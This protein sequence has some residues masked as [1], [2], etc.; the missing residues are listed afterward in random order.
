MG[1]LG[2]NYQLSVAVLNCGARYAGRTTRQSSKHIKEHNPAALSKGTVKFINSSI[3][4]HLVDSC[5]QVDSNQAFD[6]MY[7]IPPYLFK[8]VLIFYQTY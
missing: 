3:L 7:Q 4:Q 8:R 1:L 5:H 2:D 6:T